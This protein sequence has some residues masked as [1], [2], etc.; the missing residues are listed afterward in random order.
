MK[1]EGRVDNQCWGRGE[2]E[3]DEGRK[4]IPDGKKR[5]KEQIFKRDFPIRMTVSC[6]QSSSGRF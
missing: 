4:K 2:G 5:E 3:E 6:P 1:G